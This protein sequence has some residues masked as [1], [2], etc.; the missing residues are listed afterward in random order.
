MDAF[1]RFR[2]FR[3]VREDDRV[4]QW[5]RINESARLNGAAQPQ[6][7]GV[8]L[9]TVLGSRLQ[10]ESTAAASALWQ[11]LARY[12][13]R[14]GAEQWLQELLQDDQLYDL[15]T[16]EDDAPA[17]KPPGSWENVFGDGLHGPDDLTQLVGLLRWRLRWALRSDD[18]VTRSLAQAAFLPREEADDAAE[19]PLSTS[20]QPSTSAAPGVKPLSTMIHGTAAWKNP[21]WRPGGDF[22]DFILKNRRPQLYAGGA[23][24]S[25][26]GAY[27]NGHRQQAGLDFC[28]WAAE[29]APGGLQTVLAHSYG[30][31]VA[32]RA[33]SGGAS[34]DELVLL[35]TPVTRE[36][37]KAVPLTTIID[38]RLRLDPM[39]ALARR[40]QHFKKKYNVKRVILKGWRL[41]HSSTH[42]PVVWAQEPALQKL[43]V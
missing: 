37:T 3:E 13:P 29:M 17:E 8:F 19:T 15:P 31:E 38:V 22:H 27:K 12:T 5:V 7:V 34:V 33:V 10:R 32:A 26:S 4:D 21:W 23:R 2:D 6:D 18:P 14:F 40:P 9:F 25:W 1:A 28:D 36:V 42:D 16:F 20:T 24:F 11:Q 41:N 30:G 39:L 43:L 35:S